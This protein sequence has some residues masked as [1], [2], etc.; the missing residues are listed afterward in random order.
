MQ[1]VAAVIP[2]HFPFE[3]AGLWAWVWF[4]FCSCSP[5]SIMACTAL[6][7]YDVPARLLDMNPNSRTRRREEER[8]EEIMG[9]A[10]GG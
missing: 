6:A 8:R 4:R 9:W 5:I 1:S 7:E 2:V 3:E 10:C